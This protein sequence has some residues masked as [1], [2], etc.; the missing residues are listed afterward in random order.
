MKKILLLS[1]FLT[2]GILYGYSQSKNNIVHYQVNVETTEGSEYRALI[3]RQFKELESLELPS[4]K[5]FY[6]RKDSIKYNCVIDVLFD[7]L[8]IKEKE[9][10]I[11]KHFPKVQG[12]N[13]RADRSVSSIP[14][15]TRGY[16]YQVKNERKLSW[17]II[18]KI[19]STSNSCKLTNNSFTERL[20]SKTENNTLSGDEAVIPRKFRD[21]IEIEKP[22]LTK[23]EMIEEV[24]Y[25]VYKKIEYQLIRQN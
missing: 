17:N 11:N 14:S 4:V 2:L 20:I 15:T 3:D 16:V 1:V 25:N 18:V 19:N 10:T 12:K 9:S 5:I 22:L 21:P 13:I 23:E 8:T 6:N 7:K 24:I